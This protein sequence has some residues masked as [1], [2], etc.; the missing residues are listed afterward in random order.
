MDTK[1]FSCFVN[2]MGV[3]EYLS[4]GSYTAAEVTKHLSNE[5][6]PKTATKHS[7][8]A[9]DGELEFISLNDGDKL[10]LDKLAL[11]GY[12]L[13]FCKS[14]NLEADIHTKK[15]QKPEDSIAS[16]TNSHSKDFQNMKSKC[17]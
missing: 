10:V 7:K 14:L 12:L 17:D 3:Y 13:D 5:M 2:Y 9:A 1:A 11:I 6:N 16:I 15:K 8:K 4:R